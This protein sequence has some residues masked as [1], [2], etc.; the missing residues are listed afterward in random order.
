MLFLNSIWLF[1][2][3]ALTIPVIIHLWNIKPG[4]TL[5]V[6]SI[7]LINAAAK[8]SSRSLKINDKLLFFVRCLLVTLLALV[9]AVPVWQRHANMTKAKGWLLIPNENIAG[10]YHKFKPLVDSLTRAGYEFHYFN[11]GFAK[12]DLS[13]ILADSPKTIRPKT[14]NYWNLV[15]QLNQ[16]LSSD[17]HV[18]LV[19]PNG[20]NHFMGNRP[21][22]ALN[23]KWKTYTPDDSTS[24]WI[25]DAWFDQ[26]NSVRVLQGNSK[27]SGT[28]FTNFT[29]NSGSE[30]HSAFAINV[31]NGK[32]VIRFKSGDTTLI[33]IDT[34]TVHFAIFTDKYAADAAYLKAAL[35]TIANFSGRKTM[36]KQY[37]RAD[38]IPTGQSWVFWLSDQQP[39][40]QTLKKSGHFLVYK[41]GNVVNTNS[42]IKTTGAFNV[43]GASQQIALYQLINEQVTA[44]QLIW[45]DGFGHPILSRESQ[46]NTYKF[47]TRFNPAWNDLVWSDDFPQ[48]LY[49]LVFNNNIKEIKNRHERR[50]LDQEQ[51]MPYSLAET[52]ATV[53]GHLLNAKTDLSHYFWLALVVVFLM[54]RMLAHRHKLTPDND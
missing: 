37:S 49:K 47:Y 43:T 28:Y 54:E 8:K 7:S 40:I 12:A 24:T 14:V 23:L 44:D 1:A 17:I 34:T 15:T 31:N 27:P 13:K 26:D 3:A 22:V 35:Q 6:G 39:T 45:T 42:W 51:L 53:N 38:Q 32:P 11:K 18:Y 36:V 20:V 4:K 10:S 41:T 30:A 33:N 21:H 5:K 19:T 16:Y 2:I 52:H 48:L 25:Q 9:L 29:I 50:T 46:A